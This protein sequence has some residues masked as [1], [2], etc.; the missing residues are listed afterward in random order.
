[1]RWRLAGNLTPE[2]WEIVMR[3]FGRAHEKP[4]R[5]PLVIECAMPECQR[6]NECR[7]GERHQDRP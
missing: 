1:M 2:E 3:R 7:Y 4:C 6:A 5:D